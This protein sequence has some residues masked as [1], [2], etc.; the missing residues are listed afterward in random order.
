MK[1]K[2]SKKEPAEASKDDIETE[3][4]YTG[5]T[6]VPVSTGTGSSEVARDGRPA[7]RTFSVKRI[8]EIYQ[9]DGGK[10]PDMTNIVKKDPHRKRKI[11]TLVI[12]S[13][14]V[15]LGAAIG[16]LYLFSQSQNTFSGDRIVLTVTGPETATSGDDLTLE[17][18]IRNDEAIAMTGGELTVLYPT[19]FRFSSAIP[20]PASG[21]ENIWQVGTIAPGDEM[22]ITIQGSVIGEVGDQKLFSFTYAYYPENFSSEFQE[23]VNF[24]VT[25]GSS[26]LQ[27]DIDAPV[28]V[29]IGKESE[30][31]ITY[32]NDS[33]KTLER[34]RIIA[35]YPEGFSVISS[36][37]EP[38]EG[39]TIWDVTTL[40]SGEEGKITI[41]GTLA[42]TGGENREF[43][44]QAGVR[45]NDGGFRLQ[46]EKSSII[47]LLKPELS[48]TLTA[49]GSESGG[50]ATTGDLIAYTVSY[51]N[52][53][54]V[55]VK[56]VEVSVILASPLTDWDGIIDPQGGN[57]DGTKITW[58]GEQVAGLASVKPG[59]GSEISFSVPIIGSVPKESLQKNV[60]LTVTARATSKK[61]TDL[62][63]QSIETESN[64]T[65]TKIATDLSFRAQARYYN[66]EFLQVGYGPIPPVVG[67][68]TTYRIFWNLGN[69][70]N[71][72]N[73]VTVSTTLPAG[74][75]WTGTTSVSA[76]DKLKYDETTRKVTWTV[77]RIPVGAG[78]L[79][80][81]LE[82]Y[83]D[84]SITP[85]TEDVGKVVVLTEKA[86]ATG[87]DSYTE[88][89]I[90][91]TQELQTTQLDSDPTAKGKGIVESP[92]T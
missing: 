69:T 63:G 31:T 19:N 43:K 51:T 61:V 33:D 17:V 55:E 71:E 65:V 15:L 25:V 67:Q 90:T 72:V 80:S 75:T 85:T 16:G 29:G 81:E 77:N 38:T 13:L 2:K 44:V 59:E 47:L 14:V 54:D 4:Q 91:L 6:E 73:D 46:V 32:T 10:L 92:A 88:E 23:S 24:S 30:F 35:V 37:P 60:S 28:R 82:A 34:V 84:V 57:K 52:N 64:T 50:I 21:R 49:G 87:T 58:T 27:L 5:E 53:G 36:S 76:G 3:D 8:A 70:T 41:R 9:D 45:E 83:F 48:L 12:V 86:E 1:T 42:G 11:L 7:R 40:A 62:E 18:T 39:S 89:A 22:V 68:K 20:S 74:A 79:F 26:I 66:D 56:D 78:I